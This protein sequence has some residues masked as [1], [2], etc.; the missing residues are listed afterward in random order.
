L[1]TINLYSPNVTEEGHAFGPIND[2][3]VIHLA[4]NGRML[5][6]LEKIY[7]Y[8]ETQLGTQINNKLMVQSNSLFEA[9]IQNSPHRGQ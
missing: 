9:L 5:D 6:T 4:K 1:Q 8:R 3:E 2:M 7:I